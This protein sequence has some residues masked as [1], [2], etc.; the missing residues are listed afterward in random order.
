MPTLPS[1]A[2]LGRGPQVNLPAGHPR[3]L[4]YRP[5][6]GQEEAPARG[7]MHLSDVMDGVN[8]EMQKVDAV[9]AEDAV[10]QLRQ[11]QLDLSTG[12]N[13]FAQK[14]GADAVNGTLMKDYGDQF[15]QSMN[16]IGASLNDSQRSIFY[17]KAEIAKLQFNQDL[18]NHV[19]QQKDIY[20]KQVLDSGVKV[21]LDNAQQRFR[22]PNGI[23][24]SRARI[25][26]LI[27]QQAERLGWGQDL[28][29]EAK[30]KANT[31]LDRSVIDG[32]L[33]ANDADGAQSYFDAHAPTMN[34]ELR[35]QIQDHLKK[36]A[37]P[38]QA[39]KLANAIMAPDLPKDGTDLR[40]NQMRAHLGY[41]LKR[42]D[43]E[44]QAK[45]PDDPLFAQMVQT[46][47]SGYANRVAAAEQAVERNARD[48][49]VS[50]AMTP[51]ENGD[52]PSDLNALLNNP[53]AKRAWSQ[54]DPSV[55]VGIQ[56][57]L[58]HN[59]RK[60]ADPVPNAENQAIYY[61]L[62]GKAGND[63]SAFLDEDMMKYYGKIPYGQWKQLVDTQ[64]SINARDAKQADKSASTIHA[65]Q[66]LS[67]NKILESSGL[68]PNA[69]PN[70]KQAAAFQ[71]FAGRLD[72]QM[73]QFRMKTGHAPQDDD[74]LKMGRNL[75]ATV[76]VPGM[77]F[78]TNERKAYQVGGKEAP[79]ESVV[80]SEL[81]PADKRRLTD[82][83]Q[84]R[85]G[86]SPSDS[87]LQQLR[88]AEMLHANDPDYLRNLDAALRGKK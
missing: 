71:E 8:Q 54:S 61:Q 17:R 74:I 75:T 44:A 77:L 10:T 84:Q 78:G 20:N 47:I 50:A 18:L 51:D 85:Y 66:L 70:S 52:R 23:E 79:D 64:K 88:I 4:Q 56:E 15:D 55:W 87:E 68:N 42:A 14:K 45:Y 86:R 49:L 57:M 62:M 22:D 29:T 31:E 72:E 41:W 37:M 46:K 69:K 80:T 53:V 48:T 6:T 3:A 39:A 9:K 35:T 32:Y 36:T 19:N 65:L 1:V 60:A 27:E 16:Q 12:D 21:E 63:T 81:A 40:A 58:D 28:V 76:Q 43:A 83:F 30:G 25:N 11:K 82:G 2:D 13:G 26:G 5:V 73:Q 33:N 34:Q 67:K 59:A 24:L 38:M 7:L